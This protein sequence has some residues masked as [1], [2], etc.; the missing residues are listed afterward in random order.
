MTEGLDRIRIIGFGSLADVTLEPGPLTI[1]IGPNG[2]GKSN[3]LRALRMAPLMR[4]ASLQRF[5]GEE[6]GASS[7]LHYGP[8]R[9]QSITIELDFAQGERRNRYS[10]RLGFAAGDRLLY[11]DESVGYQPRADA[12]MS[13]TSI[14]AGHWESRLGE[15]RTGDATAKAINYWL[16]QLTFF[17]FHDTSLTSALRTHA[18]A[19]DDRYLRS[20]GNNLAAYLLRLQTSDDEADSAAWRRIQDLVRRIVPAVK[21]LCPTL[22]P[23]RN[24]S[25]RLDWMD[26]RDE[27]FGVHQLSD[28]SL[29]AIALITALAQPPDRLPKFVSIDE[30]ELGLH[31]AAI[32]LLAEL[33]RS[34]SHRTQV[35]FATQST[36][37]LDQF[38]PGEV[39]VVEREAGATVLKR[40]DDEALSGWLE[41][42][43]LSEV[44]EKGVLGGRP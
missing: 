13:M 3:I 37:F 1:L 25:V 15:S 26:D 40:I 18:R 14:G 16:T 43:T 32:H 29:R 36:S 12:E 11:L 34:V 6:G 8:Q 19:E 23:N 33:A 31:P 5:V 28:G 20:N 17:H 9:T 10:A 2:A 38:D 42:Y 41:E 7:L 35:L 21:E 22:L 30:P 44:F 39:V 27:R 4:T 24:G